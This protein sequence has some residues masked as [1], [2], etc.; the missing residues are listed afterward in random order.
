MTLYDNG[1]SIRAI[2]RIM[3]DPTCGEEK[4]SDLA[5]VRVYKR[6]AG[7]RQYLLAYKFDAE[8]LSLLALGVHENFCKGLKQGR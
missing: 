7:D 3:S 6:R 5:G 2:R 1:R 8:N 4:R